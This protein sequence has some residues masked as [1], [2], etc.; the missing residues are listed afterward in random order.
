MGIPVPATAWAAAAVSRAHGY[1][2]VADL[3]GLHQPLPRTDQNGE[4]ARRG[5][6]RQS[7]GQ[8]SQVFRDGAASRHG[9][10]TG[11]GTGVS[12]NGA[13]TDGPLSFNRS[14]IADWR[15]WPVATCGMTVSGVTNSQSLQ[16]DGPGQESSSLR[17]A[18]DPSSTRARSSA[19]CRCSSGVRRANGDPSANARRIRE[20]VATPAGVNRIA[21]NRRSRLSTTRSPERRIR[22]DGGRPGGGI[23]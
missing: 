2:R 4:I 13:G 3:G 15:R 14:V 19:R 18:G 21:L 10:G 20:R 9:Q 22:R 1:S 8:L 7:P 5:H 16:L 17:R 11:R 23:H 6:S 12:G